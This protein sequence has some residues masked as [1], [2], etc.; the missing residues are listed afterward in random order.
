MKKLLSTTIAVGMFATINFS[1]VFAAVDVN[2]LPNLNSATNA[3]VTTDANNMNIQI[4]AGQGGVGTL[5]WNS[6]NVGKDASVNYEF[7][8]HNQTALNKVDAAGGLSQIYGKI[9]SS[10]C[11]NCGYDATGKVILINPNGVLFG[12]GANVNLNSFTVS[13]FNGVFDEKTNKLQLDRNGKSEYGIVVL[14]GA[15]IHGDKAVNFASDNVLVYNGS[16]ISTNVAP[17]YVDSKGNEVAY[18]KVKIVTGDGVNFTYYNNGAV[19]NVEDVKISGDA[20]MIY[21]NGEIKAGNIDVRNFS[22][23]EASE[24]NINGGVLKAVKAVSGNDGNIW[25]TAANDVI[26]NDAVLQT[27][28]YSAD[29]ASRNGGNIL[30]NAA[31][32]ASIGTSD[33]DAVG[34]VDILSQGYDVVV[35]KTTI[36]TA[37]DVTLTAKGIASLQNGTAVNANKITL[38]G[39]ERAQITESAA[40]ANDKVAMEADNIW[41]RNANVKAANEFS[42]KA[43]K[44]YALVDSAIIDAKKINVSA[45]TNVTGS[46]DV[47]GNQTTIKAGNDIDVTLANVGVRENGLVAEA[48]NNLTVATDGTLSVSRLVAKKGDLTIKADKVIKGLPYTT[49]QKLEDDLTSDRGY[50]EV[51]NGKFTSITKNDSYEVTASGE[52]TEDGLNNMR[53]HIQYGEGTEKIL[54][55]TKMPYVAPPADPPVVEPPVVEPVETPDINDDQASMLNR[56][57]QQPQTI[58]NINAYNDGR[59]SFVDVFAAASQIEIEEE[60]EQ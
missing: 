31:N 52:R 28:N 5:N 15:N 17:N 54:L 58:T 10:G 25:L 19:K 24:I 60:E 56:L 23:N 45:I 27:T 32:K 34:N 42:A 20:M 8:A 51:R 6:Y 2:A 50:I 30:I 49:E 26:I 33:I 37:K 57:P 46:A 1:P 47:K 48:G 43:T 21:L 29:A 41:L 59:T 44:G 53:H 9:T 14:D 40:G 4:N 36:D 13:T 39:G 38:T 11:F 12:D 22:A 18:G 3:S 35:D 16:K 55:V 7:T